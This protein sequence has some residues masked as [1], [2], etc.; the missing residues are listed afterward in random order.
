VFQQR[1]ENFTGSFTMASFTHRARTGFTLVELLVVI[2]IIGILIGM[3]LPAVQSVRSAAQRTACSNNVRQLALAIHN[4]ESGL[5]KFPV[6]QI[7]PGNEK[8]SAAGEFESGLYSWLVPLLP[9]M[10]QTNVYDS[11][12]LSSSNGDGDD[13]RVSDTHANAQA[14]NTVVPAFLCPSDTPNQENSVLLGSANPAPGSYAANAGWPSYATGIS[15]E[16]ATPGLANGAIPLIHPSAPVEWHTSKISTKDF[17]DGTSNTALLS[18]RLIQLGNSG[19]EIR[20]GTDDRV[21]SMHIL[22]QFESL[23]EIVTQ[24][25]N[26]HLDVKE[27]AYIG[28]SWSSGWPLVAPTYMH[29]Q[30]PDSLIGHYDTAESEGNFV[31]TPSSHHDGGV[32]LAMVDGSVRFVPDSVSQDVWWAIGGRDDGYINSLDN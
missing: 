32:N 27:S 8:A 24:M 23:S 12:D 5:Q 22:R 3:L 19:D 11:L 2:A 14:V 21:L 17:A 15:G 31:V 4:Y 26:T 9:H 1:S 20:N 16:R 28:R 29:V 25:A 30:T 6:N 7:G 10:E 13:F 18:E